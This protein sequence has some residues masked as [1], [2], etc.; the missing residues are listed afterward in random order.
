M[1]IGL[2]DLV[3]EVENDPVQTPPLPSMEFSTLF[4]T[5]S[6]IEDIEII[7]TVANG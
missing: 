1:S 4:L 6:L 3:F 7:M 5:G 2:S